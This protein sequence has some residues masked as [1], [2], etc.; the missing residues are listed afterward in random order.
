MLSTSESSYRGSASVS[1]LAVLVCVRRGFDLQLRAVSQHDLHETGSEV[2]GH[3]LAPEAVADQTTELAAVVQV[4]VG[5]RD[6]LDVP[7]VTRQTMPV[8]PV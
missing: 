5:D 1:E 6:G 4:C 2:D 7:G 8:A 3:R